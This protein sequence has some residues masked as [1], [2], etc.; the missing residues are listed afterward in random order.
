MITPGVYIHF[1]GGRYD[2][3]GEAIYRETGQRYVV[4]H[5]MYGE[6]RTLELR[7]LEEFNETVT[8]DEYTGPRFK[9]EYS[10]QS[11]PK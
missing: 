7:P 1:K 5:K 9:L 8:R 4:Y 3:I 10:N 11:G 6:D 2:V